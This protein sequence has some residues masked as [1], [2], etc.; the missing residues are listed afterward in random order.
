MP[1]ISILKLLA[2]PKLGSRKRSSNPGVIPYQEMFTNPNKTSY[3]G[4]QN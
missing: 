3:F 1:F 4:F 2:L